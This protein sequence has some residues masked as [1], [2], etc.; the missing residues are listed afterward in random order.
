MK[1]ISY[2]DL[3]KIIGNKAQKEFNKYYS[4]DTKDYI[5]DLRTINLERVEDFG[6]YKVYTY[7]NYIELVD[8][9]GRTEKILLIDNIIT[10]EYYDT[11][12][13]LIK[14]DYYI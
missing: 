14:I 4:K 2:N 12:T 8:Y 9:I 1:K 3:G 5:E 13:D 7:N 11:N 10:K 6:K